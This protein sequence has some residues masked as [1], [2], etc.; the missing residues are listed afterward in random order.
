M[1]GQNMF[2]KTSAAQT[3]A[4]GLNITVKRRNVINEFNTDSAS[5]L[6]TQFYRRADK[7]NVSILWN[8]EQIINA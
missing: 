6:V 8:V 3:M 7:T 2:P 5:Q 4:F 1:P